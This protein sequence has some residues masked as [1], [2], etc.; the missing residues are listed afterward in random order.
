[1]SATAGQYTAKD[2]T[3]LEGLEPVRKRPGMYIGG[4]GKA[5]LHHLLWEVVDNS[6]DEAI[7]GY[8]SF[9]EV[10]LH[11]D[12]E[13]MTVS[14]NG[15][16][17]PVDIHPKNGRS[18]LEIILTTLHAGGKFDNDNYFT[19]G[20]LHGVGSSVVNA[21][22]TS[23]IARIKRDGILHEQSFARGI[24]LAPIA[25][26]GDARGSGT[27]IF[28]R[29]DP[30]IFEDTSFDATLIAEWLEIKSYLNQGLR[31]LFRDELRGAFH[32]FKHEGGIKDFL[33]HI[34]KSSNQP[35]IHTDVVVVRETD[36][37]PNVARVEIALQWTEDTSEDLRAFVNGI[38][39]ADGGTHEQ[40]FKDGVV[41]AMRTYFDTHDLAPKSLNIASEDIREGLKAIISVFMMDPQ[42]Q[43]Q[44]K[45][46]LNN[47][48]IR[49]IVSGIVRVELERF[50]N[51]NSNTGNAIA[52]RIIQAARARQASRSAARQ[53][54]RKRAV[55][56][57]LNLPGKLADCS[58]TD[59]EECELFIVEG[60]SAGGN[61]KQGRDRRTQAILPLR[62][63]VL[64]AEQ[65]TLSKVS[66]NKELSDVAD[67][68][69]CGLGDTFDASKLRYHK[70]ILLMDADSDGLHIST[71]LLTFFYR[72]M[73]RLIDEGYLYIAQP[74][75]YR[76]D[77]GNETF[78]VL[79]EVERER[80]L[81]KLARSKKTKKIN[82][83]RFKG[84]G[85]MMADTLKSTTL[86]P[87]QRRL[88]KVVVSEEHRDDTDKVIGNLMGKDASLRFDFIMENARY[89][90]ELDV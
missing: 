6:V 65:A 22:S 78:W 59:P 81:K 53:V 8:A 84:L 82:L 56:H 39:T 48:D 77:W 72:Y 60:N 49:N 67:A 76:I 83:Q 74:P 46:K 24:P 14:D 20:G 36:P 58:S 80:I 69:G 71:L 45:S 44:T 35:P 11:A 16:G 57:R 86:D 52:Q 87:E 1:M 79:D 13:S 5:G 4:T 55:S 90:D 17:I 7:N 15:R 64:N 10:T 43:G 63:K 27:E 21:L 41:K 42:F 9:I 85:E 68:L 37:A 61:A 30:E 32:E 54:K 38:P 47:P 19:S 51:A 50:L 62:G 33:A 40:G 18:A 12:G 29:P 88:L 34:Q 70:I 2:I 66:S 31:I 3:I 73:P 89:A 25:E 26:M 23:L 75:L 28:F